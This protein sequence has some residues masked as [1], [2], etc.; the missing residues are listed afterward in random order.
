MEASGFAEH[1][2]TLIEANGMSDKIQVFDGKI[3]SVQLSHKVDLIISEWMG[4]FLLVRSLSIS[5]I[6]FFFFL[7]WY[8]NNTKVFAQSN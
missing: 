6:S 7:H 4:T 8:G 3:E 2:Q 1:T 5:S